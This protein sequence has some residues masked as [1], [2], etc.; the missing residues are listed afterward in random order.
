MDCGCGLPLIGEQ[1]TN[2]SSML[3]RYAPSLARLLTLIIPGVFVAKPNALA[4][5]VL[6]GG[7]KPERLMNP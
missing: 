7:R 3:P 1:M 4:V 2:F 5:S 6:E